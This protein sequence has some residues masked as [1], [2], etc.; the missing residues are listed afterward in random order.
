V[1]RY[2]P[3][4]LFVVAVSLGDRP[5]GREQASGVLGSVS[6]YVWA[7]VIAGLSWDQSLPTSDRL[8][9][10]RALHRRVASQVPGNSPGRSSAVSDSMRRRPPVLGR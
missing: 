1:L 7:V 10:R 5:L 2:G 3:A 8:P 4:R 9:T 6:H